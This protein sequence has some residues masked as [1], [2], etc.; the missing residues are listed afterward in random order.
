MDPDL[1]NLHISITG[2]KWPITLGESIV[3]LLLLI[4][5]HLRGKLSWISL[6][7]N[8]T[9]FVACLT[10]VLLLPYLNVGW[11]EDH[12]GFQA[13]KW[14][15][16]TWFEGLVSGVVSVQQGPL[17][18][19]IVPE[20]ALLY[21][22]LLQGWVVLLSWVLGFLR[23]LRPL[24]PLQGQTLPAVRMERVTSVWCGVR[25][26]RRNISAGRVMQ[27]WWREDAQSLLKTWKEKTSAKVRHFVLVQSMYISSLAAASS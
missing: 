17:L 11:P 5:R 14:V 24:S 12:S 25:P 6:E 27:S 20:S 22:S 10:T 1:S 3:L 26:V 15:W 23:P 21:F 19:S 9:S 4:L 8:Q 16:W 13:C 7:L 18:V 2:I